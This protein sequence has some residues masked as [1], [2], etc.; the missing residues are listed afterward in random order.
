MKINRNYENIQD[1]YLFTNI[2][3]KVRAYSEQNPQ[4]DI[5]RLGIGDVTLPLPEAAVTAMAEAAR[6]AGV[7]VE[8]STA[9]LRKNLGDYYPAEGLLRRFCQTGVPI[10]AG[11]DSHE[12]STVGFGIAEAYEHA[13]RVGYKSVDV[14]TVDGDWRTIAL[15]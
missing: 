7:H 4:A 2:A 5:I 13:A 15:D 6:D 9:A 14:P 1:S 10:T 3:Q 11:S 8:L 12:A